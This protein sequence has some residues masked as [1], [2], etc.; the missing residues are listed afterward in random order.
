MMKQQK[1]ISDVKIDFL[2]YFLPNKI[3]AYRPLYKR[4]P[5]DWLSIKLGSVILSD[6]RGITIYPVIKGSTGKL[7]DT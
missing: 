3:Q 6:A 7:W 5:N 1:M 2:L 4:L